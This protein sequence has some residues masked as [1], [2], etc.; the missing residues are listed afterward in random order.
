[1]RAFLVSLA[2]LGLCVTLFYAAPVPPPAPPAPTQPEGVLKPLPTGGVPA[3][4][5]PPPSD[6]QRFYWQLDTTCVQIVDMYVRPVSRN[7]LLRSA[8]RG[9]YENASRPVPPT[10]Q[11]DLD[12][13]KN[14]QDLIA[15][16]RKDSGRGQDY[17]EDLLVCYHA[18]A[19]S[20][21]PNTKVMSSEDQ[22]LAAPL[23]SDFDGFGLEVAPHL[24]TDAL[25]ITAVLP[26]SPAQR[27]GLR[28]GDAITYL[29]GQPVRDVPAQKADEL[30]GLAVSDGPPALDLPAEMPPPLEITYR[31]GAAKDQTVKL[32]RCHFRAETV[33]GVR[34][35]DDNAWNYFPD[36]R[37]GI[38]QVRL[39]SLAKGTAGELREVVAELRQQGLRGLVLDLRWCPGGYLDEAVDCAR[40]FLDDEKVVTTVKSRKRDDIVYRADKDGAYTDFPMVVLIGG[41]STGGAELIAAALQGH[42]RARVAGQRSFGKASVQTQVHL[43]LPYTGM[44]LTSGTFVGPDGKTLHRFPESK[45]GDDWGVLPD[46]DLECRLSPATNKALKEAWQMVTL[47]PG[48]SRERLL[49]DDPAMDVV[50]QTALEAL[51]AQLAKK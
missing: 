27:G 47:R 36:A 1:M 12:N 22:R 9:L 11:A 23:Q 14:E 24:V 43:G 8:L 16:A 19:A 2:V 20:L 38:A 49:L 17:V 28:P 32:E 46:A 6:D 39:G 26:G 42:G 25:R 3:P 45:P 44:R 18:I 30:L 48:G 15:R 29:N 40:L 41:D 51:R 21:D 10:L 13:A 35:T 33:L 7:D 37:S 50:R 31:R 5:N 4:A 34:R